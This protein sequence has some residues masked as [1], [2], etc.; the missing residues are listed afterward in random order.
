[1]VVDDAA[2]TIEQVVRGADLL[3]STPRQ[4]ALYRALG[5]GAP[6]FVHVP[7]VL[8]P[9]GDRLAK[10]TR[11]PSIASLRERGLPAAA[12][13]GAM[14][15]SAGLGAP[16]A[17]VMPATLVAGFDLAKVPQEPAVIANFGGRATSAARRP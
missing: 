11:P 13:V 5:L 4:L 17:R 8:S 9:E 3:A 14:A 16:D 6:A 2:M 12:I 10:R 1:V 15:A 7:L